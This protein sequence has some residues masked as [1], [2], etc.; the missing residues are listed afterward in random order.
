MNQQISNPKQAVKTGLT[1][2]DKDYCNTLLSSLKSIVKNDAVVLTEV[3]N[4]T[5]YQQYEE[6]FLQYSM[7]QREVYELM[8]RKGW[9]T[10]EQ[11]ETNKVNQKYQTLVQ[12]KADLSIS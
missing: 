2:N 4:E 7:L 5:L 10:L 12:E 6:I 11:A 1:L 8:F 9:Y 3:S